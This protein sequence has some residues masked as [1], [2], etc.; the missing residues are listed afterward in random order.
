MVKDSILS[1]RSLPVLTDLFLLM[2]FNQITALGLGDGRDP[3][4]RVICASG[5]EVS[6]LP[7]GVRFFFSMSQVLRAPQRALLHFCDGSR[8]PIKPCCFLPGRKASQIS[9]TPRPSTVTNRH[10]RAAPAICRAGS[11]GEGAAPGMCL[12]L[13]SEGQNPREKRAGK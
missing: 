9:L 6:V 11:A 8:T 1:L 12:L 7:G 2:P 10:N 13:H 5:H 4:D 3:A